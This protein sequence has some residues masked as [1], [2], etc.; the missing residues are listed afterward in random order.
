MTEEGTLRSAGLSAGVARVGMTLGECG[1][2]CLP[3][4]VALAEGP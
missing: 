1:V 2:G 4:L 3:W